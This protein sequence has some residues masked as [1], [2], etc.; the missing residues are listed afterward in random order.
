MHSNSSWLFK[1][2]A[3]PAFHDGQRVLEIGPDSFPSTYEQLASKPHEPW[4]LID[5]FDRPNLT[6]RATTP[7]NYPIPDNR[8]DV[9]L[10]GSVMEHIP[11][12]WNWIK[13]VARVCK[14]GGTVITIRVECA[15]DTITIGRKP[16][17]D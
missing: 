8:F 1:K 10:S 2:Y 17:R 15:Y 4:E 16:S 13:E 9:V 12:P 3:V 5:L 11:A 14:P 6:Y 7:Y